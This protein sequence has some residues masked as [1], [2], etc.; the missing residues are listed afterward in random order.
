[1]ILSGRVL[2]RGRIWLD[3]LIDANE[4]LNEMKYLHHIE[5]D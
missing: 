1:M 5:N 2:T 4:E 3:K